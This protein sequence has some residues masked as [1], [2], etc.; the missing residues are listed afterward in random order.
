MRDIYSTERDNA[1]APKGRAI[2]RL[3]LYYEVW[4]EFMIYGMGLW[5]SA[6]RYYIIHVL[7]QVYLRSIQSCYNVHDF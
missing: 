7:I 3:A 4:L 5:T 1:L 6:C 2:K